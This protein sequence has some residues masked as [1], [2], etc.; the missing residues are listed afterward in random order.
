MSNPTADQ[1]AC[2]GHMSEMHR[3]ACPVCNP[4]PARPPM[5]AEEVDMLLKEIDELKTFVRRVAQYDDYTHDDVDEVKILH[6]LQREAQQ[7]L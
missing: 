1:K 7:I 6:A 2:R 5:P 3:L 4:K